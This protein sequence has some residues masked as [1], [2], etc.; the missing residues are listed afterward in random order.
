MMDNGRTKVALSAVEGMLENALQRASTE[1]YEASMVVEGTA[2][3]WV[4]PWMLY[5]WW[6][7]LLLWRM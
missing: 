6:E 5:S 7:G 1:V 2:S 3:A 4:Q